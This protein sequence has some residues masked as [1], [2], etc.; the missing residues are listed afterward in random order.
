MRG[1]TASRIIALGFAG[2]ILLGTLLLMLPITHTNGQWL[3]F[4]D[5]LFTATSAVC[6][7][8]LVVV[9]TGTFY[10]TFGQLIVLGLIQVG[11]LGIVTVASLF[12]VGLGRHI[13]YSQR[14]LL[15]ESFNI[16]ST[17]GVIRLLLGVT[18]LTVSIEAIGA[19]LLTLIWLDDLGWAKAVYFGLFHA[20]SAF[21]NAGFDLFG[22]FHS[23]TAFN[24][25][26]GVNL[27]ISSLIIL[28]GLGFPVLL[29]IGAHI[30]RRSEH[31]QLHSRVVIWTTVLLIVFGTIAFF[32]SE[33]NGVLQPL[34]PLGKFLAAYFQAVTPRTAGYNTVDMGALNTGTV[35][36]FVFLMFVGA[37]PISTGGGIKTT[38]FASL[39]L[40][41][42]AVVRG[43]DEIRFGRRSVDKGTVLRGV[44]LAV[45]AML[46]VYTI[47]T[48]M[49]IWE[50]FAYERILFEVTSAFGTVGLTTGITP[51]LSKASRYLIIFTM[52]VG[53]IGP[54]TFMLAVAE[55]RRHSLA[56]VP[57]GRIYVG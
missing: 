53:R 55:R 15:T 57:E 17:G 28:G 40:T 10:N 36:L 35:L 9:D 46:L 32:I 7:T 25:D 50:P 38:T 47:T 18:R 21:C 41:T 49:N 24:S 13:P 16:D 5:A 4:T 45:L 11:G 34:S 52:Y 51:F 8:G 23:L 3:S 33:H 1:L 6:V 37:S 26:I 27:V 14:T 42:W 48:L 2:T 29:D 12:L 56:R 39:L 43:D 22:G 19:L 31:L 54:L 20:I 30:R 44:A